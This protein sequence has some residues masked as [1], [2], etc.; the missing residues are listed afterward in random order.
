VVPLSPSTLGRPARALAATG[1]ALLS[2]LLA[3]SG[4]CSRQTELRGEADAGSSVNTQNIPE[5]GALP[6]IPDT[7]LDDPSLPPCA[8]RPTGDCVGVNDFPCD[9][10][11]WVTQAAN[12]CLT[13]TSCQADGWVGARMTEEGCVSSLH[14]DEPEDAFVACMVEA[15]GPFR[16]PCREG[17]SAAFLG[18]DNDGCFQG[19]TD[20]LPCT[21][22]Y[23][24]ISGFCVER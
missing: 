11:R 21:L 24:C 15:L 5:A 23:R 9:F 2:W 20:E 6:E 13:T 19:C 1:A 7:G 3:A 17:F 14:M 22:G 10:P 16:C 12:D 18:L 4:G 8:E